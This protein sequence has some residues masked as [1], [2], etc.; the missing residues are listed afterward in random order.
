MLFLASVLFLAVLNAIVYYPSLSNGF[1]FDD[2]TQ[3]LNNPLITDFSYLPRILTTG[4]GMV[5]NLH[6]APFYRP[7]H[8][9][10]YIVEYMAFGLD[11]F[12]WHVVN[13]II[14]FLNSVMVLLTVSLILKNSVKQDG[15]G[16]ALSS[17][18]GAAVFSVHPAVSEAVAWV[19]CIPELIFTLLSVSAFYLYARS[20]EAPF[21]AS[22][23]LLAA[24]SV[25]LYF[26]SNFAKEPAIFL[27]AFL[28]VYDLATG[29]LKGARSLLWYVPFAAAA[30]A[31][32][33]IRGLAMG[34]MPPMEKFYPY[35]GWG[36]YIMNL[37]PLAADYILMF[38]VP[39]SY[40]PFEVFDPVISIAEPKAFLSVGAVIVLAAAYL[41]FRQR[42]NPMADLAAAVMVIPVIPSLYVINLSPTPQADRYLY[43]STFGLAIAVAL[44][45]SFVARRA[46][47]KGAIAAAALTA[48]VIAAF[49]IES[50]AR[51]KF[52]ESDV[53]LWKGA[54]LASPENY[55]A[56]HF[57]GVSYL[58]GGRIEDAI[59]EFER[60]ASLNAMRPHPD[61]LILMRTRKALALIHW[62]SGRYD[63]AIREYRLALD[64][65]PGDF[66]AMSNLATVHF[67]TGD[68]G[69][70][71]R[72]YEAARGAAKTRLQGKETL[73]SLANTYYLMGSRERAA[74]IYRQ[75]L[76]LYPEDADFMEK[77]ERLQ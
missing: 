6:A 49:S 63:E 37:F 24:L 16:A 22:R 71:A 67:E 47:P 5:S 34:E 53:A 25:V 23:T 33:V 20:K 48:I 30:M 41:I 64:A 42:L 65:M 36:Q 40:V 2:H 39:F 50:A 74:A 60:A 46:R 18:A 9:S 45:L 54:A 55:F 4:I 28:L 58:K 61:N 27:P 52:W 76:H 26:L 31:Y 14:H 56:S 75:A 57:L 8:F 77:L 17:L 3:I 35:L 29:R 73:R 70:A 13:V 12:G 1:V 11:P 66:E 51:T 43:Y 72:L 68:Y 69:E 15:T 62:R 38:F 32:V 10:F 19:G 7:I 59:A 44:L 21:A